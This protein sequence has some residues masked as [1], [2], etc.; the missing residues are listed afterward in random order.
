MWRD[1]RKRRATHQE[2][3]LEK[4]ESPGPGQLEGPC[5]ELPPVAK[6]HTRHWTLAEE[7]LPSK[8]CVSGG[9]ILQRVGAT[10]SGH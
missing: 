5:S 2:G 3:Q 6:A 4:P 8:C 7:A 10:F 9:D 1:G